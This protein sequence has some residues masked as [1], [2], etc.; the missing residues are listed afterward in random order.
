MIGVIIAQLFRLQ[1]SAAPDPVFGYFVIAKPL[2][3]T[4]Q[5]LALITSLLGAHRF[6]RQQMCMARGK[7]VAGGWEVYVI[8]VAILLVSC[9][10]L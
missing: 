9:C 4:F 8:M 2:A 5:V 10:L 7:I 1:S 3:A 6:W